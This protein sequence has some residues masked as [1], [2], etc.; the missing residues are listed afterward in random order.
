M[1][2]Y[3]VTLTVD[4]RDQLTALIAAGKAAAKK[5]AHTRILLKAD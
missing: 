3:L 2:K 5:L 4:E 1:K